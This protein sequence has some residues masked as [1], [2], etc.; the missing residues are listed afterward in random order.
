MNMP[1]RVYTRQRQ[2]IQARYG[3]A[4]QWFNARVTEIQPKNPFV[5]NSPTA[6]NEAKRLLEERNVPEQLWKPKN[7]PYYI[8]QSALEPFGIGT[9]KKVLGLGSTGSGGTYGRV[10]FSG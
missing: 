4:I 1:E 10:V 9:I 2:R 8:P 6:L 3:P 7:A 5:I